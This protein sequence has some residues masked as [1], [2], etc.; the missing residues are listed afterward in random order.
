MVIINDPNNGSYGQQTVNPN[1]IY[2][3]QTFN[4]PPPIYNQPIP[5][6]QYNPNNSYSPRHPYQQQ[7]YQQQAYQQPPPNNAQG[8]YNPNNT[9]QQIYQQP[10]PN[11]GQLV[12]NFN[13]PQGKEQ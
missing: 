9:Q 11:N 4:G 12:V 2:P 5:Q 3:Q 8:Q 7:N 6:D 13:I 1:I 10:P